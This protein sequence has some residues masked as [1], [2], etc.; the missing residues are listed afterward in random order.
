MNRNSA[1][2]ANLQRRTVLRAAAAVAGALALPS[3]LRAA[4]RSEA[5]TPFRVAV[6]QAQLDDLKQRLARTRW[7]EAETSGDWRQ[8]V[9]LA[10]AKS[11]ASYWRERYDWRRFE[12]K[13][14]TYPQFR[15]EIDGLGIHFLH[16]R[17]KHANAL[18]LL[19]THG[20]PGSIVEF[21]KV[22]PL[23]TDP[24]AHGGKAEDAFHLIIPSLPG[25][26]FSDKPSGAGWNLLRTGQA[27]A[28]LMAR[29]GYKKWVA[30]GG[31]WG[32]GVTTVL[33]HLKPAGL[34]GIHLNWQF[35]FPEKIPEV[36]SAEEQRAVDGAN[37]FLTEG[38]GYFRMQATRPQTIGYAL[39]D[40]PVALMSFIYDKFHDWADPSSVLT[41]DE[42]L[43][44]ISLY[45]L[46][47][48]GASA[49]RI[50]WENANGSFSGG[51]LSLPVAASVFPYEIYR[52]PESWARQTYSQLVYWNTVDKGGHFA[53]FEQPSLFA[54]ELRAGFRPMR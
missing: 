26:G 6:P 11:L 4:A 10:A 39:N 33:G 17:S 23:L 8:G 2:L 32:A 25:F 31:D 27:W 49:A 46:T 15:T 41:Q 5:I 24:E 29:L 42:L 16:V 1:S 21:M 36:L 44:N 19:L 20:W 18:P 14:N 45:W 50:Y 3:P 53:A 52:A 43:D 28:T 35:V 37:K 30:Q 22:I 54:N 51:K 38:A 48:S 9:P 34:A 47:G 13:L 12:R 7:P 40:S